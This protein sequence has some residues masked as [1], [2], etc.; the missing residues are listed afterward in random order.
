MRRLRLIVTHYVNLKLASQRVSRS[1][2]IC[3]LSCVP[4]EQRPLPRVLRG[5]HG[6]TQTG[7]LRIPAG[8]P[9]LQK[10]I[11]AAKRHSRDGTAS[12]LDGLRRDKNLAAPEFSKDPLP[13]RVGSSESCSQADPF[14]GACR[15]ACES[16]VWLVLRTPYGSASG[17]SRSDSSNC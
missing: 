8:C 14:H 3:R 9:R 2:E 5:G 6:L 1:S 15:P 13:S 16:S 12:R 11:S 10:S 4:P 17:H 7:Q